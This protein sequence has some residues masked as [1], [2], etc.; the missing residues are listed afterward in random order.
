MFHPVPQIPKLESFKKIL[1]SLMLVIFITFVSLNP[2]FKGTVS[3]ISSDPPH[4]KMT[5]LDLKL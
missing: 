4:A 1:F 5:M 2:Q 3:I